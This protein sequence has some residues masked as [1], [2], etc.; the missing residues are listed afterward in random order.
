MYPVRV[1]FLCIYRFTEKDGNGLTQFEAAYDSID[2]YAFYDAHYGISFRRTLI[3][4]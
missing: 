4:L 1:F 2:F 3:E